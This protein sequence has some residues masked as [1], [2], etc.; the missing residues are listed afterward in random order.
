MNT[1]S[2][3]DSYASAGVDITAG[4][5]A[6]ELMKKHIARTAVPGADTDIGGFGGLF[7]L[8]LTGI[9]KPVLVSGTDGVGTKLKI[10][11][12]M[13][14]HDT[15]GIDCVA[16]CVNDIICAGAKPLYFL[17]YIACGKNYPE[18]IADIVKGVCEGCV[19]SGAALIGGET[20]EMPG[21]YPVD[22][23]DLAGYCTGIV[24]KD[25]II[26]NKTMKAGDVIIALP[27]SGV[28]SNG[29]SLVRKVFDV[30]NADIK[31]PLEA[32]G[33]KSLGEA[34]LTPTKI[35]VKPVLALLE[36]VKVKG[37]SH[38]TGGGFYENI[39]RSI[40]DGLGAVINKADIK[41]LPIFRLLAETG[42]ISERDM[43]NT[44]N[45]GVGMSIV[46]APE[47]VDTA[48]E[49]LK[50]NGEDAYVIGRIEESENKITLN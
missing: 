37:I 16:M 11:F 42:N 44:Y 13:D 8:D 17:D 15:V 25:K 39:P 23:Y 48:L 28:H 45:M 10:A 43:F 35:Y 49:I 34:L 47:D 36:K 1:Q 27:S 26:D 32:L 33:G 19:Q 30:E 3:S 29:F 22:E 7:E 18:K 4:Y 20:A 38:I 41:I 21:F 46:V 2:K 6:V 50:A 31:T 9:S 12:L 40:P 24:D 5:K 14:K